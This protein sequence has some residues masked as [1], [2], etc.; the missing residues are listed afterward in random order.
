MVHGPCGDQNITSPCM[1][2]SICSKKYPWHFINNTQT[3]ED[4]YPV[5]HRRDTENGG[6]NTTLNIRGRTVTI[7]N[8]WIVPYSAI[9]CRSFNIHINVEYCHSV[10]AIKY[11]CK[12]INKGSDQATFSIRNPHDKVENYLNGQYISTSESVWRILEF[13]IHNRYPTV[14]H[15]A[16]HLENCQR[17]YF[18]A[19]MAQ[20]LAQNP[21]KTTLSSATRTNL[22]KL[23]CTTKSHPIIRGLITNFQEEGVVKM[24]MG[25]Q[26]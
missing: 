15:L 20:Q 17:V 11:I 26:A 16:V 24:L 22:Q 5:Y 18:M 13:P 9:L 8:R 2:N 21:R 25:I 4:G 14:V 23:Y 12:Y 7:D 3:G 1:K 10:Q 19:G 6:R